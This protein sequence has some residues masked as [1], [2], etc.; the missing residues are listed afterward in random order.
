MC[1]FAA[2]LKRTAS[3]RARKVSTQSLKSDRSDEEHEVNV[4]VSGVTNLNLNE[5]TDIPCMD[6]QQDIQDSPDLSEA[7]DQDY[8]KYMPW[9]KVRPPFPSYWKF[10]VALISVHA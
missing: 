2:G 5:S 9:I 6:S 3:S 1:C 4:S 7:D 8:S 10:Y